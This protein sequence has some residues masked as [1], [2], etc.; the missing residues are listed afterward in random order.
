MGKCFSTINNL[1]LPMKFQPIKQCKGMDNTTHRK[2]ENKMM[3]TNNN[4]LNN[5]DNI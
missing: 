1:L 4:A 3:N 2:G 5:N